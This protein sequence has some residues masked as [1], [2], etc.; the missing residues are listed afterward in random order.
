MKK[1]VVVTVAAVLLIL[2]AAIIRLIGWD[3]LR[4]ASLALPLIAAF[5][6]LAR[7]IASRFCEKQC[8]HDWQAHLRHGSHDVGVM[9]D[10]CSR[11][12]TVRHYIG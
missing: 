11:C 3:A 5:L 8:D 1:D 6:L 2:V 12:G 4:S 9:A 10:K 7:L